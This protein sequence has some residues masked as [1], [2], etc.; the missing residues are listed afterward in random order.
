MVDKE[1]MILGAIGNT[2]RQNRDNMRVLSRG[3][4][5]VR[6][7]KSHSFGSSI[8]CENVEKEIVV[9]GDISPDNKHQW[10]VV[11]GCYGVSRNLQARDYKYPICV[12][13]RYET[14]NN[15]GSDG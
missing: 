12:V 7:E 3:G 4:A 14:D 13:R 2:A 1:I 8:G 11:Y 6:I 10:S 9:L 5:D 15:N